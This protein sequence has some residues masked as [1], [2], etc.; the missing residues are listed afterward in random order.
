MCKAQRV[1]MGT[2]SSEILLGPGTLTNSLLHLH[3][4]CYHLSLFWDCK[5]RRPGGFPAERQ[6]VL[7]AGAPPP[8]P[9]PPRPALEARQGPEGCLRQS[10]HARRGNGPTG[11]SNLA[12]A[13]DG[14][15][16]TAPPQ[17]SEDQARTRS[18]DSYV[19]DASDS[20]SSVKVKPRHGER[21]GE[22]NRKRSVVR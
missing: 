20:G 2:T 4:G 22:A 16:S 14:Y 15:G 1:S 11:A 3:F 12:D 8:P 19:F 9:P 21:R 18:R 5:C 13:P 7:P 6:C 10:R 17:V